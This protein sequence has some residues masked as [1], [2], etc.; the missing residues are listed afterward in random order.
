M[1]IPIPTNNVRK[2]FLHEGKILIDLSEIRS[3]R[4]YHYLREIKGKN[5]MNTLTVT[6]KHPKLGEDIS[7]FWRK[8]SADYFE[9]EITYTG[10]K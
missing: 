1:P 9:S 8:L 2:Q 7:T 10:V 3:L 4:N 5:A 6:L